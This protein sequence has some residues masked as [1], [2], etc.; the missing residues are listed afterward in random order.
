MTPL[1]GSLVILLALTGA[2][3]SSAAPTPNAPVSSVPAA[4]A[5]PEPISEMPARVEVGPSVALVYD[6]KGSVIAVE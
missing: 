5:S 1:R 4:V 3:W 6:E 2:P